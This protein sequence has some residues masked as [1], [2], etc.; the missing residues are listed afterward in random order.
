MKEAMT[1]MAA[2]SVVDF[3]DLLIKELVGLAS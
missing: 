3:T 1:G 2:S